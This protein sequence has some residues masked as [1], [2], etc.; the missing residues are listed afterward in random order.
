[1]S[2]RLIVTALFLVTST[3]LHAQARRERVDPDIRKGTVTINPFAVFAEF[4]T[5]DVEVKVAPAVT[6]GAGGS[7]ASSEFDGYRALEAKVRYYPAE[8]ALQGF[9]VAATAGFSSGEGT[10]YDGTTERRT[11]ETFPSVGTELSYQWILG[12]SSRFVAV[13]GIGLKRFLGADSNADFF[14]PVILPT[15]RINIGFAF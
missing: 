1:M 4:L 2:H 14:D 12:P 3:A 11:R 6:V 8:R 5:G 7:F 15:A 10:T 9:S 13:T